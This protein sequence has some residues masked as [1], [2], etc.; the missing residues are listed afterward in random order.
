M[1]DTWWYRVSILRYWSVLGQ[2]RALVVGSVIYVKKIYGLHGVNH[3][4]IQHSEREKMM[5]DKQ[6]KFPI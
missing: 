2:N 3:Q 5:T 6:T 4:I 1:V